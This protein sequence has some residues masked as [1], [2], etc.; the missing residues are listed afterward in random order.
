MKLKLNTSI[1]K[2]LSDLH[3]PVELYLK[4]RDRYPGA[5]LLESS[6]YK[7]KENSFS[8][9]CFNAIGSLVVNKE[10]LTV[11][12]ASSRQKNAELSCTTLAEEIDAFRQ[13]FDVTPDDYEFQTAGLFG[14][15]QYDAIPHFQAIEFK[16]TESAI[17]SVHYQFFQNLIVFNHFN[18]ELYLIEHLHDKASSELTNVKTLI[19]QR[20]LSTFSF[21]QKGTE[22]SNYTDEEFL[23]TIQSAQKHCYLGDVFQLV[24]SR[25]FQQ[26][27]QGKWASILRSCV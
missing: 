22:S 19:Q 7:S 16:E 6:D 24:V 25:K 4:I 14:Y 17:P 26:K 15:M 5:I 3:T 2:T 9:I 13:S 21:S 8:Y 12:L 20:A 10:Y 23:N 27:F 11:Q 1:Q 18:N